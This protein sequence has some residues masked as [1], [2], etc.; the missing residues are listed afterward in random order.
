MWFES[1]GNKGNQP[2]TNSNVTTVNKSN[3]T[4]QVANVAKKRKS[5]TDG[6]AKPNHS[7]DKPLD[8]PKV[9]LPN[10]TRKVPK[11]S[12]AFYYDSGML[13]HNEPKPSAESH[14]ESADRIREPF[15]A[16]YKQG[17]DLQGLYALIVFIY[18]TP[19]ASNYSLI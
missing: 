3:Q 16:L 17:I 18:H 7:L 2:P 4:G 6:G 13:L 11:R 14:V 1:N 12:T 5:S 19:N 15:L 8:K 9:V 10:M